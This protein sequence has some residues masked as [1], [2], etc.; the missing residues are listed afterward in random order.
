MV[1]G[2]NSFKP[3]GAY[4]GVT[5]APDHYVFQFQNVPVLRQMH[6]SKTNS[7]GYEGSAMKSWLIGNFLTGLTS[8]GVPLPVL[9]APT[10][11]VANKGGSSANGTHTITDKLWLPTEWEM[12]GSNTNS[13][14][15]LETAANQ[16]RLEYY[17]AGNDGSARRIKYNSSD[18][19]N[20]YWEASPENLLTSSFAIVNYFGYPNISDAN[21]SGVGCA[22]AFCVQ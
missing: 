4:A 22:P 17:P 21:A 7:M 10:R 12:F 19:S 13:L 8:A 5:G 9:W 15:A 18:I 20:L 2:I 3:N 11:Y 1:V 16:A 6:G 14:S